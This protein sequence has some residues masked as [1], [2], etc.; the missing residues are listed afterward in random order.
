MEAQLI[1]DRK[2][3]ND[4][5]KRMPTG[6]LCQTYEWSEH[7]ED[8]SA[9]ATALHVGAVEGGELVGA[10]LLL[11]SKMARIPGA[12][13]YAPR[14]PVV[15]DPDGPVLPFLMKQAARLARQGGGFG[16][17]VEPNMPND[18]P[19]W[20][21]A[22]QRLGFRATNHI[23]YLRNTWILDVRPEE[24]QLLADMQATWRYN[25]GKT[26]R[27]GVTVRQGQGEAD[28]DT[29]YRME[30]ET[31]EREHFYLYPKEVFRDMLAHY[32]PEAAERDGTARITL[33]VA[34]SQGEPLGATTVATFGAWAW[35]MHT[36]LSSLP[37]H[38]K[39]RPNYLLQWEAIR[40]AR[41]QGC[42]F[43]DFRNIPE[44][45]EPGQEMYG[46]YEFKKGFGGFFHRVMPTME[47]A[48]NP[49]VY[50][51]FTWALDGRQA[52]QERRHPAKPGTEHA[53]DPTP[54]AEEASVG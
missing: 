40:W 37:E 32:G 45:L 38:R 5:V 44:V 46:V 21:A 1:T 35:S 14:G 2:Q 42:A 26:S 6:H 20:L 36:G 9:R 28:L 31:A 19:R 41:S 48:L 51:P 50:Y 25:I 27:S 15:P 43:F 8:P 23:V 33:L 17:R 52:L 3:W 24:K 54:Q 34:E 53:P 18:D 11:R 13:Y 7:G 16:L 49:F 10:V 29:F 39:L 30:A 12:L 47:L 22:F 4:F